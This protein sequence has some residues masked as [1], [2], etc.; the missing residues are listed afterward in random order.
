M[1]SSPSF[2]QIALTDL[3]KSIGIKYDYIIGHSISEIVM[4]YASGHYDHET[5]VSIAVGRAAAMTQAE[6]ND[7]MVALGVGVQ[8]AKLMIKK[9]LARAGVKTGLWIAGINSPK[10]VTIAGQIELIDLMVLLLFIN[11]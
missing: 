1:L 4:G 5:P 10:A 9:V 3:L 8:K 11:S 6:G 2:I 7:G